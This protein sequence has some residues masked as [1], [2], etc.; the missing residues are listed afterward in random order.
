MI[1][2]SLILL[3]AIAT[4]NPC[5]PVYLASQTRIETKISTPIFKEVAEQAGLKFQHYNGMTGKFYLPE[6]TGSGVALFDFDND[7]DLDVF[8]VQGNVLEPGTS[9]N[10]TLFPWRGWDL[11]PLVRP[12]TL[13]IGGQFDFIVPVS[14]LQ[15]MRAGLPN[16]RFELVRYARHLPQL[17]R[18]AAVNRDIEGFIER[19]RS[20]RGEEEISEE[21]KSGADG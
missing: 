13:I 21:Q 4:C 20:W 11:L 5:P 8:L 10:R 18:P 7:G 14:V 17:E 15:R 9:P 1:G 16:A 6:I 2:R 19:R 12:P 3:L